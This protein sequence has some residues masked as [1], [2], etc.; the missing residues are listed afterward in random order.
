MCINHWISYN[1]CLI[2]ILSPNLPKQAENDGNMVFSVALVFLNTVYR[3]ESTPLI[4]WDHPITSWPP[5]LA[6][7][8]GSAV[9][10]NAVLSKTA[11][12]GDVT[13]AGRSAI[14]TWPHMP[15]QASPFVAELGKI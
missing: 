13:R 14:A 1:S 15:H 12:G 6:H 8:G 2:A 10:K 9:E 3:R 5:F 11:S 4:L 7:A